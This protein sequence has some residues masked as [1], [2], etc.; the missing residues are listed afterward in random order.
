M[1]AA[2]AFSKKLVR[3]QQQ[4]EEAQRQLQTKQ[5]VLDLKPVLDMLSALSAKMDTMHSAVMARIDGID[6]SS[7]QEGDEKTVTVDDSEQEEGAEEEGAEEDEQD[8]GK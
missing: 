4:L 3:T 8:D 5:A 1:A 7:E 2:G 6:N